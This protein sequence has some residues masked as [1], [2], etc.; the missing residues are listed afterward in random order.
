[1]RLPFLQGDFLGDP[2]TVGLPELVEHVLP[3]GFGGDSKNDE[4][5]SRGVQDAGGAGSSE[6]GEL[7]PPAL[8]LAVAR[9]AGRRLADCDAALTRPVSHAP[10]DSTPSVAAQATLDEARRAARAILRQL[11]GLA[12]WLATCGD[13]AAEGASARSKDE[14][15]DEEA[16]VGVASRFAAERRAVAV[17]LWPALWRYVA[18]ATDYC[19]GDAA[20]LGDVWNAALDAAEAAAKAHAV[21]D[22]NGNFA[23]M[24]VLKSFLRDAAFLELEP[25]RSAAPTAFR[26]CLR[27]HLAR[28]LGNSAETLSA[29]IAL[30]D[31]AGG[32][33]NLWEAPADGAEDM[34]QLEAAWA[35]L[36]TATAPANERSSS[37]PE[38]RR[39]AV[40]MASAAAV[41]A[42]AFELPPAYFA[43]PQRRRLLLLAAAADHAADEAAELRRSG[44]AARNA[45]R[46]ASRRLVLG[47]AS[48]TPAGTGSDS[49][50]CH[51]LL[52]WL[53]RPASPSAVADAKAASGGESSVD[54]GEHDAS[55]PALEA[56]GRI[57]A[58][59]LLLSTTLDGAASAAKV[60]KVEGGDSWAA[61]AVSH[62]LGGIE[63]ATTAGMAAARRAIALLGGVLRGLGDAEDRRRIAAGAARRM[64]ERCATGI[65]CNPYPLE[66]ILTFM[67]ILCA[68]RARHSSDEE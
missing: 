1:M 3:G 16:D 10:V 41:L 49:L 60:R 43:P 7:R 26:S 22:V 36:L 56:L 24:P 27:G 50:L 44:P 63:E 58:R 33:A 54:A 30:L 28:A 11:A 18:T 35:G 25:I 19:A 57:W 53:L 55:S 2:G 59:S 14:E 66:P 48:A 68:V 5:T 23:G 15:R 20:A 42:A 61:R 9:A 32:A 12:R 51:G 64:A 52:N 34:A 21:S 4:D 29:T 39:G 40:S 46:L 13:G 31:G 17:V 47:L 45:V 38:K 6:W 62:A 67:R 65:A 37:T 8:A